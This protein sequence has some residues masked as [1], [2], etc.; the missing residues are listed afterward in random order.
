MADLV[1]TV[2]RDLWTDWIDEGDAVG[3]PETGEEWGFFVGHRKPPIGP[4]DRLYIVAH[5]RLRGYAPV[6]RLAEIEG[7]WA[8]GRQGGAVAVTIDER[9]KGFRGYHKRWWSREDERPFP[10]WRTA[11]L[12]LNRK[13][14]L[15]KP[16]KVHAPDDS[17]MPY[18]GDVKALCGRWMSPSSTSSSYV[19]CDQCLAALGKS[20]DVAPQP[21]LVEPDDGQVDLFGGSP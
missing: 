15:R 2:P 14:Q 21:V 11:D 6:T 19:T 10:D 3:E 7:R 18:G 16:P 4:G 8:I 20:V 5:D 1:V 17:V 12:W 13:R 9:I